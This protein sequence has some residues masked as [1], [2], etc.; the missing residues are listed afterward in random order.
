M[1][2]EILVC[3]EGS[4]S[5]KAAVETAIQIAREQQAT[6]VGMAI[7]DKPDIL[8]G[9]PEGIGSSSYKIQRNE[10]LLEDAHRRALEWTGEFQRRCD[11]EGVSARTLEVVGRP[12]EKILEEMLRHDLTVLGKDANFRFET[13]VG[14]RWTRNKVVRN[15]TRPVLLVPDEVPQA[16][17][18]LGR[19]VLV[20][21][22]GSPSAERIL[23]SFAQ[24][25][26]GRTREV[27]VAT[28]G[29]DGEKAGDMALKAAEMLR[30][31]GIAARDQAVVSPLSD[32][33]AL[34]ELERQ[35]GAGLV[36][37]GAF[38]QSRLSELIHG[39]G[40]S[41][42]VEHSAVPIYLQH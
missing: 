29:D 22:D 38:A 35:L 7:V 19:T 20:A 17:P 34:V 10:A 16:S 3:L 14:D 12:V 24:S 4:K 11:D 2:K 33:E 30:R 15:A 28:V 42:V 32:H 18:A 37:M 27:Q 9:T 41:H 31:L 25:G 40:T 23:G 26:L 8:A 13:Q 39:S 5:G 36:V 1:I 21:Y 6:L